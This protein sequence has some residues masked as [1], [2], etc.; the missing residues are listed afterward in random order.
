MTEAHRF[1]VRRQDGIN[2]PPNT[3]CAVCGLTRAAHDDPNNGP[4]NV[5]DAYRELQ[6]ARTL[7]RIL[8]QLDAAPGSAEWDYALEPVRDTYLR[9]AR[10]V[11]R[12]PE[13]KVDFP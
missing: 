7:A 12:H 4:L 1:T 6:V 5:R 2:P 9:R 3:P 8:Y 10:A 13:I 11:V